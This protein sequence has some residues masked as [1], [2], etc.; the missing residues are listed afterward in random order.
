M[1][2]LLPK[3]KITQDYYSHLIRGKEFVPYDTKIVE[4]REH[5]IVEK[6]VDGTTFRL[7]DRIQFDIVSCLVGEHIDIEGDSYFQI[8]MT[9]SIFER[10]GFLTYLFRLLI[11]E[12]GYKII[13]DSIHTSPG[14][15]EFWISL[16]DIEGYDLFVFYLDTKF[17]RR[18]DNWSEGKIWG[19]VIDN[20]DLEY[21][22]FIID[23]YYE[24]REIT[25][26]MYDFY[27]A[28]IENV[29]DRKKC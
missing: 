6:S 16:N 1:P 7:K 19:L 9:E 15:K 10:R 25:K 12:F 11:D 13:C 26:E 29:K 20:L 27:T 21:K 4:K 18:F 24:K 17:K 5:E 23:D 28:N 2:N 3:H 22:S 8:K 14:S